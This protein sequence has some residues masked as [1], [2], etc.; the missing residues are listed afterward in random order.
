MIKVTDSFIVGQIKDEQYKTYDG[1]TICVITLKSGWQSVGVSQCASIL[2]YDEKAGREHAYKD[3]KDK[4]FG[5]FTFQRH[6]GE[7]VK[8]LGG[9][10]EK[11]VETTKKLEP[12]PVDY[13]SRELFAKMLVELAYKHSGV[14]CG[15]IQFPKHK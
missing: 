10:E 2:W 12:A 15:F 7:Y 4:L 9:A 1:T 6:W 8:N 14:D 5:M 3:A 13:N 11:E